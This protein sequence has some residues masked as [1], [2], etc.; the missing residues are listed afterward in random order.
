MTKQDKLNKELLTVVIDPTTRDRITLNELIKRNEIVNLHIGY[1][2]V[3]SIDE[4]TGRHIMIEKD[5]KFIIVF[6]N[7]NYIVDKVVFDYIKGKYV[8]TK[9]RI[10]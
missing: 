5:E 3:P 1:R 10:I 4:E 9:Y 8:I 6:E 7:F 2:I